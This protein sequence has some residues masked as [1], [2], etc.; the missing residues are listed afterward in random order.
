MATGVIWRRR[1]AT[2][3]PTLA[4]AALAGTIGWQVAVNW[5]PS[6][7]SYPIQGV[8]V[9][10]AAGAID[11]P[12][13]RAAGAD[14]AYLRATQGADGRDILFASHW[15]GTA[16]A[17]LR[18]GA[19]H[20]FSL[21]RL[22]VD[23]AD[24]FMVTVPRVADALPAAVSIDES[25]ECVTP[26]S[27]QVLID[28]VARFA[29]LVENHTGQPILLRIS[30]AIDRRYRLSVAFNRT[31]WAT[32]SF[33]PPTYLGKPWRL[34]RANRRWVDGADRPVGWDVVAR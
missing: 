10:E 23:Q 13:V 21:C 20:Q 22:A 29:R 32:G 17:G 25:P 30:P 16:A 26:P 7:E 4:L 1:A 2:A 33:F 9:T 8:D 14:F 19:V 27:R 24:N 12:V 11:W 5:H 3:L 28:E 31:L 18:R 15:A 34:W 6:I